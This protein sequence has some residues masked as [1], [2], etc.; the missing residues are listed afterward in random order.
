MARCPF[1]SS[2]SIAENV[3]KVAGEELWFRLKLP[4]AQ[5]G[6]NYARGECSFAHP[7]ELIGVVG[8]R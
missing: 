1:P 5:T 6:Q 3:R 8:M 2:L 4:G 7:Q